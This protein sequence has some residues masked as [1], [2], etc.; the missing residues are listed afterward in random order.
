MTKEELYDHLKHMSTHARG[1][2]DALAAYEAIEL[3]RK[4]KAR[5]Y[6]L[7]SILSDFVATMDEA[8][9]ALEGK[10]E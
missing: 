3:I 7:E 6:E 9:A 1:K 2:K 5:I 10:D 4:Q 8:R